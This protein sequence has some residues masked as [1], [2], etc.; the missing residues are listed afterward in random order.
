MCALHIIEPNGSHALPH[1]SLVIFLTPPS[2][3]HILLPRQTH[4]GIQSVPVAGFGPCALPGSCH[5]ILHLYLHYPGQSLR[6]PQFLL[7]HPIP[8]LTLID[9]GTLPQYDDPILLVALQQFIVALGSN[10]D[11]HVSLAFL[12]LGLLLPR[13]IPHPPSLPHILL[14]RQTQTLARRCLP[15]PS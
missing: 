5:V 9:S 14:P 6:V 2:L 4:D 7:N 15:M 3:H 8:L 12:Q 13:H 11:G 10:Y 1:Q